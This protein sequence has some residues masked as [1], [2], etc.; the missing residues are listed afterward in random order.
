MFY[1][2]KFQIMEKI[3][4]TKMSAS[5]L[6]ELLK[7]KKEQERAELLKNRDAYESLRAQV[8][9]RIKKRARSVAMEVK[10]LYDETRNET[11]AFYEVMREYGQ[12]RCEGQM[13]YAISDADFKIEVR[14]NRVKGFDERADVAAAKLVE[15]LRTWIKEAEKGSADPM[16][17]LAMSLLERNKYGDLDYKSISKLYELEDR[18][19]SEEYSDIMKL[20]RESNVVIKTAV[21]YYFYDL[22][23]MGVWQKVEPSFNRM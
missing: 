18:F 19:N 1:H 21:N 3:D 16:Y 5:E 13:S 10:A 22:T 17:Q 6:E 11:T 4:L 14:S 9:G 15:F 8:V 20:F 12:L 7:Q 2:L 23:D